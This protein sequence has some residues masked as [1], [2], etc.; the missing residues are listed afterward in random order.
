MIRFHGIFR[1]APD[2]MHNF[3]ILLCRLE[4]GIIVGW[5]LRLFSRLQWNL[6]CDFGDDGGGKEFLL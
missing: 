4:E 1:A 6:L 5:V 3:Y 2:L